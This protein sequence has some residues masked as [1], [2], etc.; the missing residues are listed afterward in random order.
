MGGV[1]NM[2]QRTVD[3]L[4]RIVLPVEMRKRMGIN[5]KSILDIK[6]IDGKMILE[7]TSQYCKMCCSTKSIFQTDKGPVCKN[8]VN[9]IIK[10]L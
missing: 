4:G 1:K 6:L 8:C 3:E 7:N 10:K 5:E 9:N 2:V